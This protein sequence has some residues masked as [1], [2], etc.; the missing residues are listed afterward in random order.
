MT[1]RNEPTPHPLNMPLS[2][3]ST[4]FRN[5]IELLFLCVFFF[6]I[7]ESQAISQKSVCGDGM[8]QKGAPP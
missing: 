5:P 3:V 8:N 7:L 6:I 1:M 4:V 2:N